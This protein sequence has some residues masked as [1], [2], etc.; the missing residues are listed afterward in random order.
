MKYEL[1]NPEVERQRRFFHTCVKWYA[2]QNEDLIKGEPATE[3]LKKYREEILDEL[4]GY[5]LALVHRTVRRRKSTADFKSVRSW[6]TLLKTLE[7]TMF[8]SAGYEYPDSEVFWQLVKEHGYD[9]ADE[10]SMKRLQKTIVGKQKT[11]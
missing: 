3:L 9:K 8:E 1:H 6:N 10:I 5:D 4:L 2:I 11:V 7:E